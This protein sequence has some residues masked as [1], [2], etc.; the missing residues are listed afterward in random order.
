[1][2]QRLPSDEQRDEANVVRAPLSD[3]SIAPCPQPRPSHPSSATSPQAQ[4]VYK[5]VRAWAGCDDVGEGIKGG[6]AERGLVRAYSRKRSKKSSRPK[7]QILLL[8]QEKEGDDTR[9]SKKKKVRVVDETAV[10]R[11]RIDKI[12]TRAQPADSHLG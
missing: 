11:S 4:R 1:M 5:Q 10:F 9:H 6:E 8:L 2:L 3:L 7:H 12:A